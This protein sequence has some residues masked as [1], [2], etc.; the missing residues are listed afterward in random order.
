MNLQRQLLFWLGALVVFILVVW[1]LKDVLLPFIAGTVLAYLLNPLTDRLERSGMGRGVA[2]MLT[3]VFFLLAFVIIGIIFVPVLGTQLVSFIQKLPGYVTRLQELVT[4]ENKAWLENTLGFSVPDIQR[5]IGDLVGESARWLGTLVVFILLV[6]LLKDILLPFIAGTVLAYLLNPLTDRLERSGMSRGVATMLTVVSFL[7]FF[8]IVGIILVP[9]LGTQLVSFIQKL[10]GYVTR[11][12]ELVVTAENKEWLHNA[13]GMSVPDIQKS[14]GD[15]VGESARWLGS[16]VQSLWSGGRALISIFSLLV[17]TPVVAF[18]V[19][20]DWHAVTTKVDSWLPRRH[21]QTIRAL[22][23]QIDRA[24]AG[25][26][27]GQALVCLIM[28]IYY[29]V[30]LVA[31]G[32][33][34]GLLIGVSTGVLTFIPYVGSLSGFL[35]GM[36]VATVQFFPSWGPIIAVAVVFII[37]QFLE[38]YVLS[39]KLVGESVGLHPVWLMFALFAFGYLLGFVGLLIAIPLAAAIGVLLR[40]ALARYMESPLYTDKPRTRAH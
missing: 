2:T 20:F 31:V 8:V 33:N 15:L 24:I 38:G 21:R 1:L 9:V 39:P 13:I 16:V 18:Y 40:F 10:P 12:Q 29:A 26:L 36:I 27:R 3:V 11:L 37:G 22:A 14:L 6:W 28:G 17:I 32:L 23:A 30:A 34:F 25:F 5:S 4:V 19:L 7:L 35:I